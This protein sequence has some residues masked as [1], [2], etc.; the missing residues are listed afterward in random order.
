ML[1][2]INS[3]IWNK[4]SRAIDVMEY[5]LYTY[6]YVSRMESSEGQRTS[7]V[8]WPMEYIC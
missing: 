3:S 2:E 4:T 6:V 5:N 7:R 1:K 8:C